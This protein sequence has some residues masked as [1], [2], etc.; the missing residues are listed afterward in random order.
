MGTVDSPAPQLPTSSPEQLS[1]VLGS[2]HE[3]KHPYEH[4]RAARIQDVPY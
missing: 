4:L 1:D 2:A 3:L